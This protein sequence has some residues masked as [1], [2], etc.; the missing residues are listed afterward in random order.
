VLG[1]D[2]QEHTIT[3]LLAHLSEFAFFAAAPTALTPGAEPTA[4]PRLYRPAIGRQ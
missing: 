4:G 3:V 2:P 1:C